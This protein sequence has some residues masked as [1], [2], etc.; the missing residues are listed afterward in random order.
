MPGFLAGILY[1]NLT[2]GQNTADTGIFSE[3]FLKQYA[4]VEV[5]I[6]KY[7]VYLMG[8]RLLPFLVMTGLAFTRARKAAAGIFIVWTGFLGGMLLAMAAFCMGVKGIILC[9]VGMLPHFVLYIPGYVVLLWFALTAP[10]S[11]WSRQ[12][13]VFVVLSMAMGVVLEG[14][15]NPILMKAFL[16]TL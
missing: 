6:P 16:G 12:K 8:I 15:I 3:Y 4:S 14:Y 9:L 11:R 10:G 2:A 1:V 5:V 7:I 13:T